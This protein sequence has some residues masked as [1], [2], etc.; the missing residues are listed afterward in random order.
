MKV[1]KVLFALCAGAISLNVAPVSQA[2]NMFN[3]PISLVVPF[4]PGGSTDPVARIIAP[5]LGEELGQPVVVRNQPGA[6]GALGA[7]QVARADADGH[8]ILLSTGVVAVHPHTLKSPGYD[9]LKD[10][11]PVTQLA[12]GPYTVIVNPK[13]PV[14][15]LEELVAY[16]KANPGKLFYGTSGIGG[17][18]H[19]VT[20]LFSERAGLKMN[21]IPYKGNG[22]VVSALLAGDIQLAFDTIPG[23]KALSDDGRV[24]VLAIT[25]AKRNPLMPAI[26]TMDES[27][28]PG[29]SAETWT[30][31]FVPAGTN[32]AVVQRYNDALKKVLQNPV[33]QERLGAIGYVVVGNSPDQFSMIIK[34]EI[35]QWKEI[36]ALAKIE[37]M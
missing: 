32:P 4:S 36:A 10:L 20:E 2:Q 31:I 18:L 13:L 1:S 30:G 24:R 35:E 7:A 14:K 21:H 11:I 3:R 9:V 29:F 25:S 15:T 37:K 22:P 19:L 26:P 34:K 23:S 33:V 27:G 17:S 5:G 16:G 6:G 28:Y 12:A 8:T